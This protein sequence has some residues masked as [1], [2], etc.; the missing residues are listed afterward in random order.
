MLSNY[1]T[2]IN[3]KLNITDTSTLQ[4]KSISPY[5]ILANNTAATANVTA[6]Q[7]R[8]TSGTYSGTITWTGT[9]APSGA[10]NHSYRLTQV[11]K[12]VT[13]Y[14]AL[15]YATNGSTLTALQ[16]TLPTGAPTPIQPTGI[17]SANSII[18]PLSAQ[19]SSSAN[20]VANAGIRGALRNNASANGF[21]LYLTFS[22]TA[23]ANAIITC[24]YWT[25]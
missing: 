24:Q 14:I 15:V 17:T 21:E 23:I 2:R 11:G 6:Q 18:Y 13:I 19:F 4:P 7:F 16:V 25:N 12:C 5:T 9:T 20:V 3:G 10:T 1:S 22:G 8:D